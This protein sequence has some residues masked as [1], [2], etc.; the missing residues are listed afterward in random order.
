MGFLPLV[1]P[2]WPRAIPAP[3]PSTTR[4]S[5]PTA[6]TGSSF[7]TSPSTATSTRGASTS[8]PSPASSSGATAVAWAWSV[9]HPP[10]SARRG[11]IPRTGPRPSESG[12]ARCRRG[13]GSSDPLSISCE[14]A[15]CAP[16]LP[17]IHPFSYLNL[18]E[19]VRDTPPPVEM[20]DGCRNARLDDDHFIKP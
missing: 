4:R 8:R 1:Q 11:W 19:T 15:F 6:A 7:R 18:I 12:S 10:S 3:G 16:T 9:G 13:S 5:S 17:K 2:C 20:D 14:G